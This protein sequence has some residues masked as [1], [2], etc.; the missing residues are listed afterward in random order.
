MPRQ[1]SLS[2]KSEVDFSTTL[3]ERLSKEKIDL[4]V[5]AA[6]VDMPRG[7]LA[8]IFTLSLPDASLDQRLKAEHIAMEECVKYLQNNGRQHTL[9]G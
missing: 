5:S 7:H 2:G 4:A 6:T 3:K 1:R 8:V 9:D